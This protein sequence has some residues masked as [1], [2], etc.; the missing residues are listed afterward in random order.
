MFHL[1]SE[2]SVLTLALRFCLT[3][4]LWL[5]ILSQSFSLNTELCE[6]NAQMKMTMTITH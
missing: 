1:N 2:F 5:L 4:G 6:N 3:C